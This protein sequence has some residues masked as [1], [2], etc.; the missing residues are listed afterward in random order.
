MRR[1]VAR[2]HA[3]CIVTNSVA[4]PVEVTPEIRVEAAAR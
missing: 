3:A 2:A 1:V 4:F